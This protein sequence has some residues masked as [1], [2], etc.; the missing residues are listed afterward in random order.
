MTEA[1]TT[2][3]TTTTT[4]AATAAI[5]TWVDGTLLP[6]GAAA[7]PVLDHGL[8]YGDG[9]FEGI[10]FYGGE[11]FRLGEHLDRLARSAAALSLAL[12]WGRGELADAVGTVIRATGR[13][14]GYIRLVVTR[15]AGALGLDPRS[16]GRPSLLLAG[17]PFPAFGAEIDRGLSVIV[18][19]TRQAPAD[20]LDP[21]IKSLNY[22]PRMMARLEA[23]RAGADE[24]ILLNASGYV[25][26]GSTDNVFIVR[27]GELVTPPASDGALE[28]VTRRVVLELAAGAAIPARIAS[29]T[30]YDLHGA[31]E[32]F[33]CGT[34][35]E[36][37]PVRVVDGR[38]LPACPGPVFQRVLAA[39][40][41]IRA[42]ECGEPT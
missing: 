33:L 19:S 21:R 8:L 2:V 25:T 14:S 34:G 35:I 20:V 36:L 38:A 42:R 27:D 22:L 29:L 16:C 24:A 1:R 10:R 6:A 40:R 13:P 41:V 39:F 17:G 7:V 11:P 28:G 9:V 3:T 23:I 31:D 5:T 32:M 37:A 4:T 12:P 15:G 26:E 30:P 18:A